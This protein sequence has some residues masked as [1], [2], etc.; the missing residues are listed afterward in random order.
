[1]T[2]ANPTNITGMFSLAQYVNN[3]TDGLF[4]T[5]ILIGFFAITFFSLKIYNTEIAFAGASFPFMIICILFGVMELIP[6]WLVMLSIIMAG[7]SVVFL[8]VSNNKEY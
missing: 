4:W 2:Y 3:V 8:R 1:M 5:L 6:T 7:A